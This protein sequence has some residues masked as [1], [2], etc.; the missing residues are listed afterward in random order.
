[1]SLGYLTKA[2]SLA[3]VAL[4]SGVVQFQRIAADVPAFETGAPHAGAHPY[5]DQIALQLGDGADDDH[6][7]PPQRATG[8]TLVM[9]EAMPR[10]PKTETHRGVYRKV[11]GSNLWWVRWVDIKGRRR[12]VCAGNFGTAVKLSEEKQLERRTGQLL[13]VNVR[14]GFKFSEVVAIGV[15]YSE[16][17]GQGDAK[18]FKARVELVLE[19]FGDRAADSITTTEL[20]EWMDETAEQREWSASTRN[21]YK[22]SISSCFREAQRAGKVVNNP[23]RLV[24]RLKEMDGRLRYLFDEEEA[25]LRAKIMGPLNGRANGVGQACLDQLDVAL[26]TEMR[27]TEQLTVTLDQVSIREN[28]I[29]LNKTKNGS[30][31][32]HHLNSAALAVLKRLLAE[33]KR[34]GHAP[35]ARLFFAQDGEAIANPRKWFETT[36]AQNVISGQGRDVAVSR[37]YQPTY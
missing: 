5:D 7:S 35:D 22:F 37:L 32:Y 33:H 6:D 24:R 28:H 23:M 11:K 36:L 25:L 17:A 21:R 8:G 27:K 34:A 16:G 15:K 29:F 2:L 4:D 19:E 31:R 3:T 12:T 9:G 1:M 26:L 18:G 14:R 30:T 13:P 20:Q 10:K